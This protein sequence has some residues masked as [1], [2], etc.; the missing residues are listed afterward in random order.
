MPLSTFAVTPER[1]LDLHAQD[2]VA[3]DTGSVRAFSIDISSFGC[4]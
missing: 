4:D 1:H 3:A 2:L